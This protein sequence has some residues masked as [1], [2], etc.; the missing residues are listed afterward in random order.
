MCVHG[1]WCMLCVHVCVHV[2]SG[3]I[4]KY[5]VNIKSLLLSNSYPSMDTSPESAPPPLSLSLS[6]L[7]S[8]PSP[9]CSSNCPDTEVFRHYVVLDL[10]VLIVMLVYSILCLRSI[11]GSCILT[12]VRKDR[13][14]LVH[15]PATTSHSPPT[16]LCI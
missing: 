3:T 9:P 15:T 4:C 2:A 10:F 14:G 11:V 13:L 16:S 12:K 8:L 1:A 5:E 6:F 7:P